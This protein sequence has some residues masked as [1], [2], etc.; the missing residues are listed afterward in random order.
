VQIVAADRTALIR[1]GSVTVERRTRQTVPNVNLD[2]L[3]RALSLL[4]DCVKTL[5]VE[6]PTGRTAS[7]EYL[8]K[9]QADI[10][11][12]GRVVEEARWARQ[13]SYEF[14]GE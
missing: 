2:D 10:E 9:L 8:V 6:N 12:I 3:D 13:G 7:I 14:Q 11:A 4:R 5:A 1:L